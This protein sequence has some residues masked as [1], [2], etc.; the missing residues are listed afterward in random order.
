MLCLEPIE[1]KQRRERQGRGV[2][3]PARGGRGFL[4][5]RSASLK[6]KM[7]EVSDGEDGL[8]GEEER[9]SVFGLGFR[10]LKKG[11]EKR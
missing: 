7:R 10:I 5:T 9:R 1:K 11:I 8:Q 2:S 4:K 3:R 6:S